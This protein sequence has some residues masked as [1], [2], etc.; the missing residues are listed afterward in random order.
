MARNKEHAPNE[1]SR[2]SEDVPYGTRLQ[3]E[4]LARWQELFGST[5][6]KGKRGLRATNQKQAIEAAVRLFMLLPWQLQYMI[7]EHLDRDPD[8]W[9]R[10]EAG[11]HAVSQDLCAGQKDRGP[12][13]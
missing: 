11:L 2:R 8:W 13:P 7:V 1:G 4:T 10:L 12:R 3:K 6:P 5:G 9:D